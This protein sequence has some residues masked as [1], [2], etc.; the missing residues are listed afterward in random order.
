MKT[1]INT[2]CPNREVKTRMVE[3]VLR[4]QCKANKLFRAINVKQDG[5]L[6]E[7]KAFLAQDE[8]I[9]GKN[10]LLIDMSVET[11]VGEYA[12]IRHFNME[13]ALVLEFEDTIY[14]FTDQLTVKSIK[15]KRSQL[16]LQTASQVSAAVL[17][18]I[19]AQ[20]E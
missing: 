10:A 5:T 1:V 13:T 17:P 11:K 3:L 12:P 2:N 15:D 9:K 20:V 19:N 7:Y 4:S 6:R 16:Q 14:V 18:L 8:A